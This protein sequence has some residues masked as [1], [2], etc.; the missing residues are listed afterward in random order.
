VLR[1]AEMERAIDKIREKFG[2][3]AV[4]RGLSLRLPRR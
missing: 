3:V 1:Q 2:G 4:Q